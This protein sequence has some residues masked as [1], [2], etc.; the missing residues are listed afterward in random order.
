M[1]ENR[2]KIIIT[3]LITLAPILLGVRFGIVFQTR[4]QHILDKEMCRMDGAVSL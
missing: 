1:K 4:L 2:M 3:S